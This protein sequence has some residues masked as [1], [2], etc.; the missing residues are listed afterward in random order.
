MEAKELIDESERKCQPIFKK[1][2]DIAFYNSQKVMRA[3][4]DSRVALMH[5]NL[6]SGYGYED[7]GKPKLCE[8]FAKV[9]GAEKALVTPHITC[10]TH[11]LTLCLQ[12][13]LRPGDNMLAISGMPYDTLID[14]ILG[15]GNGSLKDFGIG[16]DKIDMIGNDFNKPEIE[17]RMKQNKPK[18]VFIQ[19]SR[20][21]SDRNAL[22]IDTIEDIINFVRKIDKDVVVMVDNCYGEFIDTK[23]PTDVGADLMAGS[24]IKNIGGGIA[25]TGGYVAGKEKWV[26]L[27]A[28]RLT[29]PSLGAEVGSYNA[30]YQPFFEGLFIAPHVVAGALKGGALFANVLEKLGMKVFPKS[31]EMPGDIIRSVELG[32]EKDLITFVQTIQTVCPID[33]FAVPIPDDM[34]GYEDK[35]IMAAGCFIQG[36]SIELSCDAPIR[37]PYIAYFQGG[38]TYEHVKMAAYEIIRKFQK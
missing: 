29:A 22:S 37:A 6:S 13:V 12:G 10:G 36:A 5:M 25:P 19:R 11:A 24:L 16:F 15:E 2:D 32:N 27:C 38:I 26:D 33:S 20:G 1:I 4:Q 18:M 31:N 21:Y 34:P 7:L 23:E 3:F 28:G 14:V 9:F 30:S 17:K 8:V 35:V